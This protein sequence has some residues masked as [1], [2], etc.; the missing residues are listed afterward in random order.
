[1]TDYKDEIRDRIEA[2]IETAALEDELGLSDH[3]YVRFFNA[4][5]DVRTLIDEAIS[6]WADWPTDPKAAPLWGTAFAETT[7][8]NAP[9]AQKLDPFAKQESILDVGASPEEVDAI[10]QFRDFVRGYEESERGKTFPAYRYVDEPPQEAAEFEGRTLESWADNPA[11]PRLFARAIRGN[12]ETGTVIWTEDMPVSR[13]YGSPQTHPDIADMD[14][15]EVI[16][17][18]PAGIRLGDEYNLT[19]LDEWE[20]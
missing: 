11:R 9:N 4:P 3:P 12:K 15:D 8:M 5:Q 10:R 18:Q 6:G 7:N 14:Q 19:P 20:F 13:L 1:M 17:A 16:V 2:K